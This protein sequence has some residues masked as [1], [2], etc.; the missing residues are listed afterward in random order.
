MLICVVILSV[1]AIR[2]AQKR[3][4]QAYI[5]LVS[6]IGTSFFFSDYPNLTSKPGAQVI[7]FPLDSLS[8]KF[9][10]K[11]INANLPNGV[12]M[13]NMP[14]ETYL[15]AST[16]YQASPGMPKGLPLIWT[17]MKS[18]GTEYYIYW[19]YDTNGLMTP[20]ELKTFLKWLED[21][22]TKP[23]QSLLQTTTRTVTPAASQPPH[24]RRS[25]PT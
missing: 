4:R 7:P 18:W 5:N 17:K 19:G 20:E 2:H 6:G 8:D 15:R 16:N 1:L 24:Q 14:H 23:N 3:N 10:V 13:I 12:M 11:I 25:C 9:G 21:N 22:Q